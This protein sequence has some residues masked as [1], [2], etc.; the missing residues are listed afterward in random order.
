[1]KTSCNTDAEAGPALRLGQ[2][3][4]TLG[5]RTSRS[6]LRMAISAMICLA[7]LPALS[8]PFAARPAVPR[9]IC[10]IQIPPARYDRNSKLPLDGPNYVSAA[11]VARSCLNS[12]EPRAVGC[13]N[14]T[15]LTDAKGFHAVAAR[16]WIASDPVAGTNPSCTPAKWR[17]SILRHERAHLA[18]WPSDHPP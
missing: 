5:R 8:L 3:R 9:D 17:A 14:I 7:A 2:R 12:G 4:N 13:T 6:T 11:V 10:G 15:G 18:G 16:M 1:M